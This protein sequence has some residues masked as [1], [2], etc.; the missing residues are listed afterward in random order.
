M[1]PLICIVFAG[2]LYVSQLVSAAQ[3][4]SSAARSCAW[5]V[6]ASGCD[7]IPPECSEAADKA[8]STLKSRAEQAGA[9]TSLR[10][11]SL[12]QEQGAEQDER[13]SSV[14]A[15]IGARLNELFS[16][17]YEARIEEEFE[18]SRLLGGETIRVN[19]SF[20]L[21]CN[22]KPASAEGLADALFDEFSPP[23]KKPE[24][25]LDEDPH[26]PETDS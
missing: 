19:R 20:S 16:D 25:E 10:L 26:E 14:L 21:P 4:A 3:R 5:R 17:R 9:P 15:E 6:A 22:T 1:L 24:P 18:R 11:D 8:G 23:E 12:A 2:V 7:D 13:T